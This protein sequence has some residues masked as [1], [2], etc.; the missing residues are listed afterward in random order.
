MPATPLRAQLSG[1]PASWS[2]SARRVCGTRSQGRSGYRG[3]RPSNVSRLD[4][5]GVVQ[6]DAE[7]P[8]RPERWSTDAMTSETRGRFKRWFWRPPRPHGETIAD[9]QVSNLELFYDLVYVAVIGQAAHHLAEHVTVRGAGRV[10]RRLRPDLDRVDQRVAVPGGPWPRGR[11]DP[12]HRL[13]PDGHPGPAGGVHRRRHRRQR[14]GL[15]GGVRDLP[16][17]P[18]LAVVQRLASGPPRP[19]RVPGGQRG[20]MWSAW[21]CRRR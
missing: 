7:H 19:P 5:A 6:V 9:R 21:A 13:R 3:R 12:H 11:T 20:A 18:D 1:R 4:P 14:Q 16:G 2:G 8:A 17:R 15:R 10:R